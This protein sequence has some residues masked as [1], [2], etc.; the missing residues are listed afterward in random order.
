MYEW[1]NARGQWFVQTKTHP[2]AR[3]DGFVARS[4]LVMEAMLA[5]GLERGQSHEDYALNDEPRHLRREE[6]VLHVDGDPGNDDPENLKLFKNQGDLMKVLS[7]AYATARAEQDAL[8]LADFN[9]R[10]LGAKTAVREGGMKGAKVAA[11]NRK[12]ARYPPPKR[13][14]SS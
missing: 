12:D 7:D 11:K 14:R 13:R 6:R 8:T 3:K 9:R 10:V 2:L 1:K 5:A 4:K